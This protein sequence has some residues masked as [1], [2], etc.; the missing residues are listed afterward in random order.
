MDRQ[1]VYPGQIPLETDLLNTN[2][3]TLVAL[4]MLVQDVLGSASL[5]S[6]F[7]CIPTAPASLAVQVTPGRF[8][9]L[10][11]LDGTAYSSLAADTAHQVMKQ[12]ILLDA[13]T[14]NCPAPA[15]VGYSINYLI[16]AAYQDSDTTPVT[17]P[18]YNA[19]N[20]SQAYSGPNNTG[21]SQSTQRKGIVLLQAKAGVAAATGSQTTPAADAGYVGLFVVTVANGQAT[22]TSGNITQASGAPFL[23]SSLPGLIANLLSTASAAVGAGQIGFSSSLTYPASS[24]GKALRDRSVSISDY[25]YNAVLDGVTDDTAAATSAQAA[26]PFV[27]VPAGKTAKVT[28]GLNYWQFWGPGAVVENGVTWELNQFPQA[29]SLLK[30]YRTRTFGNYENAA[31][32]SISINSQNGQQRTNTQ[33]LGTTTQGMAQTYTDRDHVALYAQAYS[34]DPDVT[35]AATTYTSTT[36]TDSTVSTLAAAGKLQRGMIIDTKHATP[37]TGRIQSWSGNT[38]TVDGWW[39]RGTGAA[40]TPAN[41]T[42]AIIN[43]NTKVW[44]QNSGLFLSGNAT[45]NQAQ[46]G[47]GYELDISCD[48]TTSGTNVWGFDVNT[49]GGK[50]E[51]HFMSRGSRTY[52][53]FARTGADNAFVSDTNTNAFEARDTTTGYDFSTKRSGTVKWAVAAGFLSRDFRKI[54]SVSANT[55]AGADDVAFICA[56]T[57]TLTLPAAS[58]NTGRVYCLKAMS[59]T[60]TVATAGGNIVPPNSTAG[61]ATWSPANGAQSEFISDGTAW[62]AFS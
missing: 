61:A 49:L 57:M 44:V 58:G 12:G 2:R 53:F 33:I 42:G 11:N 59:G 39:T 7:T 20:P 16:E 47:T 18:Y 40:A 55:T 60:I 3:N 32:A 36:L 28:A 62:Y 46:T 8:Y 43:P 45:N 5:V 6:G 26:A 17:L 24:A 4:A 52:G 23:S 21:T 29:G 35:S 48:A 10:Q 9:S 1:I 34:F 22:I 27:Y 51:A 31:G 30:N 41:G 50:P 15:T 14:L 38:I 25:P 19:S 37:L 56:G 54:Q 13:V